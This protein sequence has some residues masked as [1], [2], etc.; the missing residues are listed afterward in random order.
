VA[1]QRKLTLRRGATCRDCQ[2]GLP[3]GAEAFYRRSD[4]SVACR[5]C[6][7]KAEPADPGVAGASAQAE[8]ERRRAKREA[9]LRAARAHGSAPGGAVDDAPASERSWQLGAEGERRVASELEEGLAGTPARFLHD[10]R[11]PGSR[12]NLDHLVIAPRGVFV[13][14]AKRYSGR[15][16]RRVDE[17]PLGPRQ[18]LFIAGRDKT[19]LIDGAL[20]QRDLVADALAALSTETVAVHPMLCFVD[21]EFPWLGA[22]VVRG[23]PALWPKSAVLQIKQ[24]GD[25]TAGQIERVVRQLSTHFPASAGHTN[26]SAA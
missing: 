11:I 13:I 1:D 5:S 12:A 24:P 15:I 3:T 14:D 16:E 23:V 21:G 10:R 22:P 7:R 25:L 18:H 2:L 4:Q 19:A 17:G 8:Y 20:K 6:V 9:K 26:A